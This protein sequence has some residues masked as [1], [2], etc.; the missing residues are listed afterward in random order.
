MSSTFSIVQYT[1]DFLHIYLTCPVYILYLMK[2]IMYV[3][4]NEKQLSFKSTFAVYQK[5]KGVLNV[6]ISND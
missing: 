1:C 2:R 4:N 5:Y 3:L 6:P